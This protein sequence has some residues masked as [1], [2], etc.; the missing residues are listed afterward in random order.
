M[1]LPPPSARLTNHIKQ[2]QNSRSERERVGRFIVEGAKGVAEVLAS[3]LEVHAVVVTEKGR[4]ALDE[5]KPHLSKIAVFEL[6]ETA[7]R[8]LSALVTPPGILVVVSTPVWSHEQVIKG[9]KTILAI[10]A[11]TDPGNMGTL[12]RTADWFGFSNVLIGKGSVEVTNPKVVQASMGSLTRIKWCT[13]DLRP[14][15]TELKERQWQLVACAF[16]G[17]ASLPKAEHLCLIVGSE[18][19]GVAHDII[20]MSTAQYTIPGSGAVESLNASVAGGIALHERY[21]QLA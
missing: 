13:G 14:L 15:L 9:V 3:K 11:V 1:H 2:L 17:E 5:L 8:P 10:D 18:S 12:L 19:H 21:V 16:E 20:R 4:A 7:Y 6:D